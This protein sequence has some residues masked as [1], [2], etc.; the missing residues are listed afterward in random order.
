MKNF[1]GEAD[2][3]VLTA[4]KRV[5]WAEARRNHFQSG[6][7]GRSLKAIESAAFCLSLDDEEPVLGT[8]EQLSKY[9]KSLLH[10]KT[11]DRW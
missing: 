2:L 3:A 4:G 11:N 1:S 5:P 6:I 7:N 9:A 10:G 8:S